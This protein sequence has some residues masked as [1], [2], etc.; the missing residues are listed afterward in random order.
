MQKQRQT[1][2]ISPII[3]LMLMPIILII[4]ISLFVAG[5]N[6]SYILKNNL[7]Q[8]FSTI[9]ISILLEALPFI[10][11]GVF[12]SSIIQ[13]FVSEETIRR[14]IPKNKY[15]GI[16]AAASIGLFFPI[17]DCAI[18]PVVRRLVNK[19]VPM[20]IGTAF[21]LSVPIINPVVLASTYYAFPDA[22]YVVVLR[23]LLGW[24]S[25]IVIAIFLSFFDSN[26]NRTASSHICNRV[27]FN[28][29]LV[30]THKDSSHHLHCSCHHTHESKNFFIS[31][32]DHLSEELMET[33]RF[34][35][36][37]AF[38]SSLMQTFIP[39]KY[40][41]SLSKGNISSILIML[42]LAYILCVCSETDAF[43]ART[44]VGK[45]TSGSILAFLILGPMIDIKNTLML[46]QA[47]KLK[48][49]SKLIFTVVLV[50]ISIGIAINM[51]KIIL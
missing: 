12:I 17:C 41:L 26:K 32:L 42:F 36:I 35:I 25:A 13:L 28:N 9:F 24:L 29:N 5:L 23:G 3:L 45:F 15:L 51:S 7:L 11:I 20:P 10:I 44:F 31:I 48:F 40:I 6:F 16:L 27:I 49:T 22:P 30:H 46:G 50:C 4:L 47:F 18:V 2:T 19:G 38:L 39:E 33:F 1:L 8:C 21:M 37:G 43:I 14:F 34:I